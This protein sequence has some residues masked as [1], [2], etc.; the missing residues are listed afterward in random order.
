MHTFHRADAM[1]LI[2]N[3]YRTATTT[4]TTATMKIALLLPCALAAPLWPWYTPVDAAPSPRYPGEVFPEAVPS[5]PSF[6]A[7]RES[8][9]E[10]D[11]HLDGAGVLYKRAFALAHHDAGLRDV[12][13]RTRAAKSALR[14]SL[15]RIEDAERRLVELE[16]EEGGGRNE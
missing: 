3:L 7:V 9:A 1:S 16:T 5:C 10:V 8:L 4:S 12:L 11:R 6:D 14:A 15:D 13:R 2:S